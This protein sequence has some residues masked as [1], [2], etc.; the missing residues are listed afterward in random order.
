MRI[1]TMLSFAC[2]AALAHA[3]D[4]FDLKVSN[5]DVLRDKNVQAEL[6][7]TEGQ[8]KTMNVYADKYKAA[9]DAKTNE[10]KNAKKVPDQAF[11]KYGFDI[12]V[13][14]RTSVLKTLSPNQIKRLRELTL[15][16]AGPRA[17]LDK[18]VSDRVGIP[19]AE[20]NKLVTA[21]S[22]GDGKIAKIKKLVSDK[23]RLKYKS[24]KP[25]TN[26][27]ET[28]ALNIKFSADL[29]R[30]MKTH[31]AEMKTI[32]Q[33]AEAKT[34]AVVTKKYLDALGVLMGKPFVPPKSGAPKK[35]GK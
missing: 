21:V 31:E 32:L 6:Q 22:E 25:P 9:A 26:E 30:E 16:A 12:Y 28:K 10:Y 27:K 17:L 4:D 24:Q 20:Y 7:V 19:T 3:F 18:N 5:I 29:E 33:T 35:P 15:Q 2:A 13:Q 34:K 14:L 23:I 11:S 1:L 8:R